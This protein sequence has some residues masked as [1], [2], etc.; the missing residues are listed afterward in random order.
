MVY[1][2]YKIF[3]LSI[4]INMI[5]HHDHSCSEDRPGGF[6]FLD[7]TKCLIEGET[8]FVFDMSLSALLVEEMILL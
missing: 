7:T 4:K 5:H 3:E 6:F 2:T 1:I 8:K